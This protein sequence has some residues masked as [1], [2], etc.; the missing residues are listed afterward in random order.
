MLKAKAVFLLQSFN[1]ILLVLGWVMAFMAYPRL[2]QQVPLWIGFTGQPIMFMEKSVLFFLS[3]ILQTL[4]LGVA[5]LIS[6]KL[7]KREFNPQK[8]QVLQECAF[9]VTI[10][11][12]LIF[13]HIQ[14]SVIFAAHRV[15]GGFS[16]FYFYALFVVLLLL[17][18]YFRIRLKLIS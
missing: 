13:V 8:V 12:Q 5:V 11:V 1:V 9:L 18:P 14:K 15:D 7:K 16:Q 17:I 6:F 10:F 4:T 2:P 3:P